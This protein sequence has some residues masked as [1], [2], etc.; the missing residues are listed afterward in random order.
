ME[1]TTATYTA[2][3]L[4]YI[5]SNFVPLEEL[6]ADRGL[7]LDDVRSLISEG[8]LPRPAYVLDDGTEMVGPDYF[9][10]AD[11]AVGIEQLRPYFEERY[12][13]AAEAAELPATRE[14]LDAV[15]ADYLTGLYAVCLRDVTPENIARKDILVLEIR[16][17]LAEQMPEHGAWRATLRRAVDELDAL[18]KPFAPDYDRRLPPTRVT[19]IEE[20]RR[21][22][23]ELFGAA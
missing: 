15:W 13:S 2:A 18:E 16:G 4:D 14:A 20:T 9:A 6:C 7:A 12:K 3:D 1:Q 17:L 23:P 21:R 19:L 22:F 11:A 10:L 8:A 5:E